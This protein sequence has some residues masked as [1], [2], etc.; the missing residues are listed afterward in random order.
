MPDESGVIGQMNGSPVSYR[1]DAL[2]VQGRDS[3]LEPTFTIRTPC[4]EV[5]VKSSAAQIVR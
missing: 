2:P 1:G 4:A 5:V 3:V